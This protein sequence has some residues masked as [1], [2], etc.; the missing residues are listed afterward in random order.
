[1]IRRSQITDKDE[2][3]AL[4]CALENT[5]LDRQ[6]FDDTFDAQSSD[7][8]YICFVYEEDK[9][10]EGAINM[11]IEKQ[12]HHAGKVCEIMEL[13]VSET[14]RN[15]GIGKQLLQKAIETARNEGCKR[16]ELSSSNWRTDSHRFYMENGFDATHIDLTMDL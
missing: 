3:Y 6:G 2:I 9:T 12:L 15:R 14:K 4:I 5:V 16:I 10:I 7:D 1:M 13:V 11:R 8:G